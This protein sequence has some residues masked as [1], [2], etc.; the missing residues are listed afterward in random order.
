MFVKLKGALALAALLTPTLVVQGL[1]AASPVAPM[2][3]ATALGSYSPRTGAIFNHPLRDERERAIN[4]HIRLSIE[5]APRGSFIRIISWNVKSRLYEDAL[6]RAHQRGAS[7][8]LLMSNGL[9]ED[10]SAEGTYNNL[11]RALSQGNEGRPAGMSSWARTC[12]SSCRGSGG[13]AHTKMYLFSQAG[14]SKYVTMLSSAN[15][16]E[17][18]AMNQWNDVY[19]VAGR[20]DVFTIFNNIF[21]E[22][23]ADRYARP[24]YRLYRTGPVRMEFLPYQGVQATGDPVLGELRRIGCT[25]AVRAGIDGYTSIRIAQTAI[26]DQRGIEIAQRLKRMWNAGCKIRLVYAV[27]GKQVRD[28]LTSPGGRG[29]VPMRQIVQDFDFD[30]SYDRYLHMK[31]M[32]V[33]GV[34]AG[35]RSARVVWNGTQN[36]TATALASDEAG[37]RIHSDNLERKY[38]DWVNF[39]FNNPPPQPRSTSTST[40]RMAVPGVEQKAPYS[41]VELY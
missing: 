25:G 32:A 30:G 21:A 12:V 24:P 15:M 5:S 29:P 14:T 23:A 26:L 16:T 37:F 18:A 38:A 3:A 35:N 1:P 41:E 9:A 31:A 10:Q 8:R 19:T 4:R 6:I 34:Y 11:R 22:A 36:W 39:L 2:P 40:A 17:V 27:M 20:E 13:I 28:I 7:V 33:S